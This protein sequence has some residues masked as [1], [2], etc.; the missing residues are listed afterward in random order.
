MVFNVLISASKLVPWE[1][2][3]SLFLPELALL[4]SIRKC[5]NFLSK[6]N[7]KGSWIESTGLNQ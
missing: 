6:S 4:V 3:N 2:R 5:F 1:K 7:M